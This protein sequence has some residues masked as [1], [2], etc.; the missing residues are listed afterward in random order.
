LKKD[1]ENYHEGKSTLNKILSV[2]KSPNDKSGLGFKS[3]NKNKSN[4][5]K[6]KKGQEQVKNLAKIVCFKCK[7]EG[8]HVR[9]CP[10]KKKP[11]S[12]KQQEKRPQVQGHAKPRVEERS[13]PKKNQANA[14]LVEKSSEKKVKKRTCYICDTSPTYP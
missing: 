6:K 7:I 9:Y 1:L 11:L 10:L 8:H 3:N 2:Q 14:P 5:N 4:I 12:E 13:L